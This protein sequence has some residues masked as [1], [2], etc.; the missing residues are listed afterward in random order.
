VLA[1]DSAAA[2]RRIR[3]LE[4]GDAWVGLIVRE[5]EPIQA[6]GTTKLRPGDELL[7]VASAESIS[8]VEWLFAASAD[9]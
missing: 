3:D 5:G 9:S 8:Q 1:G 4:L 7:V 2:G 6:R